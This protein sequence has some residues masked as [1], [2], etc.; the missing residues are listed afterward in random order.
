MV[1]KPW[2]RATEVALVFRIE[3]FSDKTSKCQRN[4]M[5]ACLRR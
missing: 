5:Q 2:N 3:Y 4:K 1:S